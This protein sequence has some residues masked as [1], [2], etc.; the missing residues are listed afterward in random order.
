MSFFV[1]MLP[2]YSKG[3]ALSVKALN[4]T[5]LLLKKNPL[6]QQGTVRSN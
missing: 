3:V 2:E 6:F 5:K 1:L 4:T